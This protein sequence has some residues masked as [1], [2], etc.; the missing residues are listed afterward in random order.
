M[1]YFR[2]FRRPIRSRGQAG[3]T[4]V[5]VL[6][7][8]A[9]LSLAFAISY[10][11]A[12]HGLAQSRN[13]EEHSEALGLL[14]TQVELVRTS[15]VKHVI[16]PVNTTPPTG[17]SSLDFCMSD[18]SDPPAVVGFGSYIVPVSGA[19]DTAINNVAPNPVY[20]AQC[21]SGYYHTSVVYNSTT[22]S[23]D[24]RIRWNGLS[25]LG[26]QQEELNYKITSIAADFGMAPYIANPLLHT[27]TIQVLV[28]KIQPNSNL[29]S[30]TCTSGNPRTNL[31]GVSPKLTPGG[32][33][34]V[35][36]ANG[37]TD[38]IELLD[39]Q[40]YSAKLTDSRYTS[41]PSLSTSGTAGT[42]PPFNQIT[43]VVASICTV[44]PPY[45]HYTA[46]YNHYSPP[47]DHYS[48]PYNHYS[49]AYDHYVFEAL[50]GNPASYYNTGNNKWRDW[51]G[52]TYFSPDNS[53]YF[54]YINY[55]GSHSG[56][57][58]QYEI[59]QLQ[60]INVYVGTYS[61][62]WGYYSDYLGTY[63]DY[64]GYYTDYLGYYSDP[65]VCS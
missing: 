2:S 48:A 61:D 15:L 10:S 32:Q 51:G 54:V 29:T 57:N 34:G 44:P 27:P 39:G 25:N 20:P 12:T 35:T 64:W 28:Q 24:F 16:L 59:Y 11:T 60:D 38:I 18:S 43:A 19:A 3:D 21:V 5:E 4:I 14:N 42:I 41:C 36:D 33:S 22:G 58:Y 31:A 45:A 46:P 1:K 26:L 30:P 53:F 40:T 47:Y 17:S 50:P 9:V 65:P 63:S 49:P 8:L 55:N 52:S 62:Y 13:A 56:G 37:L 23:Y 6:I 7:V